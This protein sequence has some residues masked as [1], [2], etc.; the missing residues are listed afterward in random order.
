MMWRM[1][2]RAEAEPTVWE[3]VAGPFGVLLALLLV[4][5]ANIGAAFLPLGEALRTGVHLALAAA[6]VALS[7]RSVPA[8]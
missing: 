7:M 3:V 1:L 6:S 2:R 5:A 8:R 4:L